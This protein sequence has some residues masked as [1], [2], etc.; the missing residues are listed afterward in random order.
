MEEEKEK[1]YSHKIWDRQNPLV[2]FC[3]SRIVPVRGGRGVL[4]ARFQVFSDSEILIPLS[5][6]ATAQHSNKMARLISLM[7]PP[8]VLVEA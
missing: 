2:I 1:H 5:G 6:A 7:A 3:F 8:P 4:H